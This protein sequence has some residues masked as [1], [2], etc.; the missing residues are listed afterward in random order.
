MG[1]NNKQQVLSV[2]MEQLG[3]HW[4]DFHEISYFKYFF[5]RK[6]YRE[7]S[8]FITIGQEQP[9]VYKKSNVHF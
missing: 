6:I 8:S 3:S 2:R 9:V 5:F 4:T 1:C 7:N